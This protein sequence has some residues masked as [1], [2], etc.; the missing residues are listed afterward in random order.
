MTR[1][2]ARC[3]KPGGLFAIAHSNFRFR[4]T[5]GFANFE[6]LP[7]SFNAAAPLY[8]RDNHFLEGASY[9]E[10]VFRKRAAPC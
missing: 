5:E 9:D 8:G 4:D 6:P 3:L 1:D 10:A 2:L 7:L